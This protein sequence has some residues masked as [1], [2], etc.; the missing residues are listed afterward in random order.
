MWRIHT[1]EEVD[2]NPRYN[3]HFGYGLGWGLSDEKG[4]FKVSHGGLPGM[5]SIV[6]MYPDLNLGIVIL[7]NT[8]NG[9]GGLLRLF[10]IPLQI[11]ISAWT[12]LAGQIK[13]LT[14]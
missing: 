14:G 4:N 13:W 8:E 11:I 3:S 6:T 9:G 12:I 2:Q 5:L 1:V 10:Q 7:T